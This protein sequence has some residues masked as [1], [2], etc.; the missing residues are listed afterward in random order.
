MG[1]IMI[2]MGI[3]DYTFTRRGE[4]T[5]QMRY[6]KGGLVT[7]PQGY[8]AAIGFVVLGAV[9]SFIAILHGRD[10]VDESP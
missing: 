5:H 2:T 6:Y 10:P 8:A 7:P 9:T 4:I 3:V 1:L